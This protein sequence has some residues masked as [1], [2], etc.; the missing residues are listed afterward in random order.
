MVFILMASAMLSGLNMATFKVIGEAIT[1]GTSIFSLFVISLVIA[2]LL[3]AVLCLYLLN[4]AMKT[5]RQIDCVPVYE[6][7]CIVFTIMYGLVLFDES[8][9]YTW[10]QVMG[11]LGGAFIIMIGIFILSLK[12]KIQH[13]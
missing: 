10:G 9:Y 13:G 5:F 12:H 8:Q 4:L 2:G 1:S 3:Q 7:L 6:S 11:I